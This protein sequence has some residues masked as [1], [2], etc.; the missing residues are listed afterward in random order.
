MNDTLESNEHRVNELGKA[1]ELAY[2]SILLTKSGNEQEILGKL[3][4]Y[5]LLVD[6]LIHLTNGNKSAFFTDP[7]QAEDF[8]ALLGKTTHGMTYNDM[9]EELGAKFI[10]GLCGEKV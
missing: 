6:K 9:A 5:D 7:M 3:D 8:K 2:D 10:D 1:I 4:E